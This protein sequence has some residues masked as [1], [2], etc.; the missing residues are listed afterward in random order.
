MHAERTTLP[1]TEGLGTELPRRRLGRSELTVPI[2]AIGGYPLGQDDVTDAQAIATIHTALE[3]GIDYVDTSPGYGESERRYGLALAGVDR[4]KLVI[5]TKTGTH[6]KRRAD[7]SWDA[8]MWSVENSLRQLKTD[9]I[10]LLLVHDPP[11]RGPDGMRSIF[12]DRGALPALEALKAQG[13]IRAIGLGQ[14]RFDYHRQAIESGRFDVILTFNNY[15]PLDVSAADWLL[16]LARQYDVGVINGAVMAHGLLTGEDPD[17]IAAQ[18]ALGHLEALLPDARK[19]YQWCRAQ[20]IPMPAVIFQFSM[21][22]PLIHCTLTGVKTPEEFMEN[23]RGATMA[24][25]DGIW[26][27]LAALGITHARYDGQPDSVR[28]DA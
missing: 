4:S 14:K 6:P 25:P 7:Y 1:S 23:L 12:A 19:L 10:D 27:E 9:Y 17:A 20:G 26:D 22:Q 8:T 13:V 3:Q 24:L 15:H 28:P 21:R 5:S 2:F 16:P 11:P 18:R